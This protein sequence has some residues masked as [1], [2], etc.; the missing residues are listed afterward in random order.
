M[1]PIFQDTIIFL[2][3]L[4]RVDKNKKAKEILKKSLKQNPRNLL[5]GQYI[6]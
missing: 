6:P 3:Y 5:I 2:N 4:N 1:K